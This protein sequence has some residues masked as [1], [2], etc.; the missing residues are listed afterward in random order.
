MVRATAVTRYQGAA[1]AVGGELMPKDSRR[2][3]VQWSANAKDM[4]VSDG[5]DSFVV[6]DGRI[7]LQTIYYSVGTEPGAVNAPSETPG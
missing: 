7:R 1:Q 2:W 6:E 4:Y 3:H 5:A